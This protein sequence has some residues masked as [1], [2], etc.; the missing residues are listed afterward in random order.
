MSEQLTRAQALAFHD[1]G[2]WREMTPVDL[3]T[4]QLEQP[5]LCV[6]WSVFHDAVE[7]ALGRGVWTHEFAT[8]TAHGLLDELRA[9]QASS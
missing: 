4:F 1:S 6:P 9:K 3:A 2:Y 7:R 8:V 5:F